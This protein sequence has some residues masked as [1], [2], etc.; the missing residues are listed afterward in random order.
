MEQAQ[1]AETWCPAGFCARRHELG[2]VH[3][4]EFPLKLCCSPQLNPVRKPGAEAHM[5][6]R[7][8]WTITGYPKPTPVFHLTVLAGI[9]LA[10]LRREAATLALAR[11]A[12]RRDCHILPNSTTTVLPL[13]RL[14]SHHPY[15]KAAKDLLRSIPRTCLQRHGWQQA[16]KESFHVGNEFCCTA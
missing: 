16:L 5:P 13:D 7:S 2:C 8:T 9:V 4:L 1:E 14:K 3:H 6:G 11:K 10:S 12:Q 15:S